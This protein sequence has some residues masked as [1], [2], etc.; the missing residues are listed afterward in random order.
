MDCQPQLKLM[1][2]TA[3]RLDALIGWIEKFNRPQSIVTEI[4]APLAT[5][6]MQAEEVQSIPPLEQRLIQVFLTSQNLQEA[7]FGLAKIIGESFFAECCL[8]VPQSINQT[9]S[10]AIG[11][12]LDPSL[13]STPP[14]DDL[15]SLLNHSAIQQQL[16]TE[17]FVTADLRSWLS[18]TQ[19]APTQSQKK[20]ASPSG[21]SLQFRAFLAIQTHFQGQVNGIIAL[22]R[23]QPYE[24]KEAD[25]RLLKT[26]SP[27][28]AIAIS[29][30]HLERQVQQQI[31]Y[32]A[33]IDQLNTAIRSTWDLDR[34]F[35]LA[36]EGTATI[37]QVSRGM[38]LLFKYA[39]PLQRS[40]NSQGIPK[41]KAAIAAEWTQQG[42]C[43]RSAKPT[44]T[45]PTT[46]AELNASFWASD[47][48][49]CQKILT[50]NAEPILFPDYASGDQF[51]S[52]E[53]DLKDAI[54]PIF[55]L[56]TLPSL[57]LMPLEN[58]GKSLGCLVLQHHQH[59]L[60][61]PEEVAFVKLAVA[62]LSTAIIQT[63]T[64]QQI[65]AVV[66]ERTAQLQ[67]SLEV[68]AK[69]YEKTRQQVEQLRRL[70]QEREEFLST[71]SHELRTP[72]TSMTLAI[73]MLR[74]ADLSPDRQARYLDILEQQCIQ[75][76]NLI[77]DLLAL[78][79]LETNSTSTHLQKL[80]VRYLIR[81]IV[82]SIEESWLEK[83]LKLFLD[84]PDKPLSLYTDSESLS[85]I[86]IELLTN[87]RKYSDPDTIVRFKAIH[88]ASLPSNQVI[89]TLT[90]SGSGILPEEL[91]HIFEKFRRG[92]GV[93]KKAIQGTGLGL[94]LVKGLVEHLSGTIMASSYPLE[95][96]G[97]WETCFTLTLPQCP[98]E[99][100]HAIS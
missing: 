21:N 63:R 95:Q 19:L 25:V 46:E 11:W 73:R 88:E 70:N 94:A 31:R 51:S 77:N 59:R 35:H 38:I 87:A 68:Q 54:A 28:V 30:T 64:L 12:F 20:A 47:C 83:N 85:R 55:H 76:T 45:A 9:A 79:K 89:L 18:S 27:Q 10:Q 67:R 99:M 3:L 17:P 6:P 58:Q 84:L 66:Q 16:S 53:I 69:L 57:L 74:Q 36:V 33:L 2:D 60:W 37:L 42:I 71:V 48:P 32:Q 90:N 49:L 39:D 14:V 62:Q 13:S 56:K 65:Q 92:Q 8:I 5:S 61:L 15:L 96:T 43:D 82:Q 44:S 78:R 34:I 81:D 22:M 23:S 97:I 93:T 41:A 26:L 86:L 50:S 91:P 24:W 4:D 52:E 40:R 75:E 72:L 1:R 98:D 29:Q 7:L 100:M 80:D